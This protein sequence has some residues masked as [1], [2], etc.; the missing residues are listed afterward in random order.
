MSELMCSKMQVLHTAAVIM[1][2]LLGI[3]NAVIAEEPVIAPSPNLMNYQGTLYLASDSTTPATGFQHIEFR[4]YATEDANEAVWAELHENVRVSAKGTFSVFL[5]AGKAIDSESYPLLAKAFEIAPLWLGIKVGLDDEMPQRQMIGS[6]P[7]ALTASKATTATHGVPP[8]TI[9]MFAGN[10]VPDGWELCD[11]TP[12]DGDD[13]QYKDL[14]EVIDYTWGNV[15]DHF[16]VPDL[17]GQALIGTTGAHIME[18]IS[19]SLAEAAVSDEVGAATVMLMSDE[20]PAH[21]H[22]FEDKQINEENDKKLRYDTTL[23]HAADTPTSSTT[24]T[25]P[26]NPSM[27]VHNNVQPSTYVNF[28]IKL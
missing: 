25:M 12:C 7:Y 8:G 11:G 21:V 26:N 15:G 16:R 9:V 24:S 27:G 2:S 17:Q 5:G 6:A 1:L 19:A 10:V 13:E 22:G 20:I 23:Q 18:G 14:S 28:I 4:L 3:S